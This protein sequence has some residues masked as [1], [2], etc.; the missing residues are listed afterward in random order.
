MSKLFGWLTKLFACFG[1]LLLGILAY[2]YAEIRQPPK[3][4][5]LMDLYGG[6][7]S[8]EKKI[9]LCAQRHEYSYLQKT[10]PFIT[11]YDIPLAAIYYRW[12]VIHDFGIRVPRDWDWNFRYDAG[13]LHVTAPNLQHLGAEIKNTKAP[14][15]INRSIFIRENEMLIEMDAKKQEII[16]V[17]GQKLVATQEVIQ[18]SKMALQDLIQNLAE[19]VKGGREI[20]KVIVEFEPQNI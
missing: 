16:E 12:E 8:R 3:Q 6:I 18:A 20:R 9:Y 1:L 5:S 11:V 17:Q 2:Q 13:A 19:Q 4:E 7:I 14:E 10:S 15:F